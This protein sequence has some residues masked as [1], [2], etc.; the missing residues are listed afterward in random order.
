MHH[1]PRPHADSHPILDFSTLNGKAQRMNFL[2]ANLSPPNDSLR[3]WHKVTSLILADDMK[4]ADRA[5]SRVEDN[6]R[7][8][9]KE[10][11]AAGETFVPKYFARNVELER[12]V[13]LPEAT[14]FEPPRDYDTTTNVGT[15]DMTD[16]GSMTSYTQISEFGGAVSD[17][18]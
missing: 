3:V 6:H 2:P 13:P 10:R 14:S 1:Q 5:K 16:D 9:R 15:T 8:L 12:W 4:R 11:E 17:S 18:E 7:K